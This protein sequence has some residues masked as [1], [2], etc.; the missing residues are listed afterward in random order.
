LLNAAEEAGIDLLR[1]TDQGIR[2]QKSSEFH[3]KVEPSKLVVVFI[4]FFSPRHL[5]GELVEGMRIVDST[6]SDVVSEF[7]ALHVPP[8]GLAGIFAHRLRCSNA[9]LLDLRVTHRCVVR[10]GDESPNGTD[11]LTVAARLRTCATF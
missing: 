1:S 4:C 5:S 7:C 2:Y 3:L 8:S 11:S 6:V 10:F 9:A